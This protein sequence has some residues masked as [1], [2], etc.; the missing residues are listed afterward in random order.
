MKR[1]HLAILGL[2]ALAGCESSNISSSSTEEARL[3]S[4]SL[5]DAGVGR[6]DPTNPA[7]RFRTHLSGDEAGVAT[8]A[9]GQAAFHYQVRNG[10]LH[11]R[12]NISNIENVV[13]VHVHVAPPGENG[14]IVL[15]LLGNPFIEDPGVTPRGNFLRGTATDADVTGEFAGD[16][17]AL[18]EAIRAGNTY[19][20]VHTTKHRGGE[21]RGQIN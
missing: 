17:A 19:L 3:S 1:V 5:S 10:E 20:N 8:K 15:P 7:S 11:Y 13:G 4:V 16:L 14:P 9:Q 12:V 6:G 2:F 21:V 18:V